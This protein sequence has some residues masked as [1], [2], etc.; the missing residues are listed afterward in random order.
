[1]SKHSF[2]SILLGLLTADIPA[3][4]LVG[5]LFIVGMEFDEQKVARRGPFGSG[6]SRSAVK[7]LIRERARLCREMFPALQKA[8]RRGI[9]RTQD[10]TVLAPNV[11]IRLTDSFE[12]SV[13]KLD[14]AYGEE[15][16]LC[17]YIYQLHM[18]ELAFIE[19][20]KKGDKNLFFGSMAF[21]AVGG[22]N[23]LQEL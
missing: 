6:Y 4:R 20:V 21:S 12:E 8:Y 19:A 18:L 13:S 22:V 15:F 17:E 10:G 9:L 7:G 23:Q 14:R 2:E 3:D 5:A 16:G 1:M 11:Q